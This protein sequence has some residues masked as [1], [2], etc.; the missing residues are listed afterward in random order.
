MTL[1]TTRDIRSSHKSCPRNIST[2]RQKGTVNKFVILYVVKNVFK[3]SRRVEGTVV[4]K[5]FISIAPGI[6]IISINIKEQRDT[7]G[8]FVCLGISVYY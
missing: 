6:S 1:N 4:Y 2:Q 8:K 3:N 7:R 5:K